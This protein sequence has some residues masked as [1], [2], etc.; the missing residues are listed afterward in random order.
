MRRRARDRRRAGSA[1][2]RG[3]PGRVGE[4]WWTGLSS[5]WIGLVTTG[6]SEGSGVD[7]DLGRS[8]GRAARRPRTADG[9]PRYAALADRIRPL[10]ADGRVPL[11]TRL[12]A[13][14]ELAA[15][16]PSAAP[17][18][19]PP[20][21][22]SARTAGPRPAGAGTFGPLPAGPL[23][24]APGCRAPGR[25]HDRPGPRGAVGA[26]WVPAG[27]SRRA[28]GAAPVPAPARLPPRRAA[29][30]A[31]TDRRAVHRPRPADDARAGA[32]DAGR[33]TASRWRSSRC[34][35]A[36]SGSW[37]SSRRIRTPSMRPGP[38]V[39]LLPTALDPEDGGPGWTAVERALAADRPGGAYLMPDFQ[40]PTGRLLDAAGRERCPALRRA[41]PCGRR[42]DV[43]PS[44][45]WTPAA[46][47]AGRLRRGPRLRRRP[48]Q[49]VWGGLRIGWV[50]A[51]ADVV[52]QLTAV[53]VRSMAGPVVEQL[54]ACALL[55]GAM[56]A[57]GAPPA[58]ARAP[59]GA[60]RMAAS[61]ASGLAG[62]RTAGGLRP[63][64]RSAVG[65]VPGGGVGRGAVRARLAPG[66]LFG[67]GHAFDDR[68]GCRHQ[69]PDVLRKAVGLWRA[70]GT[71]CTAPKRRGGD[72]HLGPGG[73][74]VRGDGPRPPRRWR[75][76]GPP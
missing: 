59:V 69:P 75:P 4:P 30:P 25:R 3:L 31:R 38:G 39:R 6:Q 37:S 67:T 26:A 22:A 53:A 47:A 58:A 1:G 57:G 72:W 36:D 18:S 8:A 74:I 9:P 14:R 70:D 73:L 50:R 11:G 12:P 41:G 24:A 21:P 48:E 19:P 52:R 23:P 15:A 62:G 33:C 17:R 27:R 40:N 61:P 10:V 63:L 46:A 44:S 42:R 7:D 45:G 16:L 20:T 64:V 28:R 34:C 51:D 54:A 76:A 65:A 2:G 29:G 55:D 49:D 13:E 35:G 32:G 43:E 68:L 60:G 5:L 66:P 56:R 71:P